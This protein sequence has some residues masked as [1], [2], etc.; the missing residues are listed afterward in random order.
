MAQSDALHFCACE[1]GHLTTQTYMRSET[2]A[3]FCHLQDTEWFE[4]KRSKRGG[5]GGSSRPGTASSSRP[6]TGS[7]SRGGRSAAPAAAAAGSQ[8]SALPSF[9][10]L[11][12]L[13]D[14]EG[15]E[16]AAAKG[17]PGRGGA[18]AAVVAAVAV[19]DLEGFE[20]EGP[21]EPEVRPMNCGIGKYVLRNAVQHMKTRDKQRC[22]YTS[23]SAHY[24]GMHC[25]I[26][27]TERD[28]IWRCP[29]CM[30][31]STCLGV[32]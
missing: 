11:G 7:S 15:D 10:A 12:E 30:Q 6:A 9:F 24:V 20:L 14:A 25:C 26:C 16:I 13:G 19:P 2:P 17:M 32:L 18:A 28:V 23:V 8:A 1:S 31:G 29:V 5:R 27:C 4:S 21:D 22:Y 3:V